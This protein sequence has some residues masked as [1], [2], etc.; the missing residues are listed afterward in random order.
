MHR[1]N[2]F[3]FSSEAEITSG[4]A[5]CCLPVL[6]QFYRTHVSGFVTS[7]H[8]RLQSYTAGTVI[9][10][11]SLS[12]DSPSTQKPQSMADGRFPRHMHASVGLK[13]PLVGYDDLTVPEGGGK[14]FVKTENNTAGSGTRDEDVEMG[15]IKATNT[16]QIETHIV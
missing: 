4:I 2:I 7:L 9:D 10:P 14:V 6:P 15:R 5:C 16:V 1:L 3:A 8:S 11:D 12:G 13:R